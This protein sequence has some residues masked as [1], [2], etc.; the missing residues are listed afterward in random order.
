MAER[1]NLW[2][3]V[4]RELLAGADTLTIGRR[5]SDGYQPVHVSEGERTI[6][7]WSFW[8]DDLEEKLALILLAAPEGIKIQV[9]KGGERNGKR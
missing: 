3:G 1:E 2:A 9:V 5:T 6:A 7:A 4:L 8:R